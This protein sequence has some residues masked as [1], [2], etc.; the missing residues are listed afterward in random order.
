MKVKKVVIVVRLVKESLAKENSK[1]EKEI[2]QKLMDDLPAIPW[3]ESIER[4]TVTED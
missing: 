1:I 3:F 4:V 2:I